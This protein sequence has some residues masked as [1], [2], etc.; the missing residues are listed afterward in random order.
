MQ[1][2]PSEISELI[3]ARIEN[4]GAASELRTQGTIVSVTDG[5]VRIHGLSEVMSGE[6]I[7]MPGNT[8]GVALNLERDS[9]GAVVLGDYEHIMEGD[10]AKCTGR[11]LEV[12]VG[13]AL[14]GRVVNAL[15]QPI[16]GKGPIAATRTMPIEKIAPGVIERK[17]VDQPVQTGLKAIDAMVP[18]GRGQRELI[19][20]DR[21]TGK[22]AVAIDAI[23]NQ[24]GTG[25]KCIYVAVGQKASSVANVVR[26]LEEHGAM[27]HTIVVAATAA[28]AAAMQFIA[29]YAGCTMGEYFRD[30]GEDALIVY[31]DL[32]KQAWAYRQISLLLRRPPGR[33][34]YPGDVFYLHSRLLERAARV[35]AEY[36]EKVTGGAVKGKT[37]SL[38]ALPIIETQAGDVSAFVPTNVISITDGQIFLE[39]DLFNAGIRPAINAGLSV[40]RVGGAAQTKVIKKLGGGVRLALAQYRELAAFAQFASDLDDA[41]RKQLERGRRVTELMKQ[42][43][44]SPMSIAQMALSLFAVNKGYMDDIEVNKILAFESALMAYMKAHHQDILERIESTGNLDDETEKAL[45]AAVEAFKQTGVY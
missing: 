34:A 8:F 10:V 6:M 14:L 11:I 44:Y 41:T 31:D 42:P 27:E 35:N 38:T 1:L 37:G 18:V 13:P 23:I 15:G 32:T 22:T 3:K 40:S 33:E 12:P 2:N 20:G 7:E 43:Q 21:Q 5:I 36:V 4:L 29:P 28:D 26:K 16:D 30:L 9:V 24:K 39:T 17:S 19:I 45:T 25:V